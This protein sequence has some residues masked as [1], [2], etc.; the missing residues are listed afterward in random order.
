MVIDNNQCLTVPMF[1]CVGTTT[2]MHLRVGS[3][4]IKCH[5]ERLSVAAG[6]LLLHSLQLCSETCEGT[7]TQKQHCVEH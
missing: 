7:K 4:G 5:C 6:K 2:R 1:T 3:S